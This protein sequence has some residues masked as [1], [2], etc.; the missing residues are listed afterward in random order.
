MWTG[1]SGEV[2]GVRMCMLCALHSR[3]LYGVSVQSRVILLAW[4]VGGF[5]GRYWRPKG[6]CEVNSEGA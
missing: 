3:G 5:M 1:E 4:S 6:S 2:G